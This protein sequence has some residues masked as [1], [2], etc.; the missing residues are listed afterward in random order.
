M[1][2]TEIILLIV[3]IPFTAFNIYNLTLGKKKG[4]AAAQH[5]RQVFSEL[6]NKTIAEMEKYN[7]KFDKKQAFLNDAGQGVQLSF[8]KESR[9]M[10]LTLKD[11]FHVIPFSDV[12]A[13]SV[14]N[15]ELNGKYS[16]I[17]VEIKTTDKIIPIVFGTM[18]RRPKSMMGKM[19]IE[20]ATEFCNLVNTQCNLAVSKPQENRNP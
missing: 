6:E 13:C 18:P 14:Q 16:N 4:R 19:V 15:D 12:Q 17:R 5:Y 1:S 10:A 7:L 9:K 11:V 3:L 2:T 8:S 20:E